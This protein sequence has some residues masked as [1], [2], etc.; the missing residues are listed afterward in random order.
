MSATDP[1]KP[2]IH[3]GSTEEPSPYVIDLRRAEERQEQE[4]QPVSRPIH[5]IE[6]LLITREDVGSQLLENDFTSPL[7]QIEEPNRH[8]SIAEELHCLHEEAME[9]AYGGL[10]LPEF[11]MT[12][13]SLEQA[14]FIELFEEEEKTEEPE[15][16]K[17]FSFRIPVPEH[18]GR[19]LVSFVG[20]SFILV[21]PIHAM[22]SVDRLKSDQ[23]AVI[24]SGASALSNL[25]RGMHAVQT[26]SFELAKQ[27]FAS[28]Q[29]HFASAENKLKSFDGSLQFFLSVLPTT[30]SAYR[31][32]NALVT[33]GEKLSYAAGLFALALDDIENVTS[34]EPIVKLDILI[35]YLEQMLPLLTDANN[36]L[37]NVD[38]AQVPAAYQDQFSQISTELPAFVASL[39][40]FLRFSQTI[41]TL[42]GANDPMRYLVLFQNDTEIRPTGGFIGSFAEITINHGAI[43]NIS[44]PGGGS[45]DLQGTLSAFVEAPAP[46]QLINARFEFQDGNWFPDFPTSA[47]KLLWFYDASNGPTVDGVIAL[48]ASYM[49][50]M[51]ALLGS[52]DMPEYDR[53][54]T[55][56]N[57]LLETQKIVE[58]EC[59]RE[60]NKP[61]Q[62]IADLAPK[63]LDKIEEASTET[64]L[65]VLEKV[66][67]GFTEKEIQVYVKN[68]KLMHMITELG[69]D[70]AIKQTAGDYL[71]I[72]DANIGGGKTDGT[73]R[74]SVALD[75][76]IQNDGSFEN[77]LTI[78]REHPGAKGDLFSGVNNVDYLRVYV[79]EGATLLSATGDFTP[80]DDS[81]FEKSDLDLEFDPDLQQIQTAVSK[82]TTSGTDI[83][84]EFGKTVFGNWI[85]T[86]P[87]ATSTVQF[88][89]RLPFSLQ[90]EKPEGLWNKLTEWA[91]GKKHLTYTM[92][93][94][95]QSGANNRT[96]SLRL[97]QNEKFIPLWA[98]DQALL[99]DTLTVNNQ[100]DLFVAT[101]FDQID[102]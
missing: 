20:L 8:E 77:T 99:E 35:T 50:E 66:G 49:A 72:I 40:D 30:R 81:L 68:P 42:L 2:K 95:K 59:D 76:H 13:I 98:S 62:F 16:K 33:S 93:L 75:I 26:E 25:S 4:A 21:L 6:R 79:P 83:S 19:I 88:K 39:S 96:V 61:K 70:G 38:I 27:D 15:A 5:P 10:E 43:E 32:A 1:K 100:A 97:F 84:Q 91:Q 60:E 86:K 78:T 28:A 64:F 56:D 87:G 65:D 34:N 67:E 82:D 24:T 85:Q 11:E 63:L 94:Q 58:L 31:S 74:E 51:L 14:E 52:I 12:E 69:Y 44:I 92:L 71:M 22:Q 89:Y 37:L 55:S 101:L 29:S 54:I 48:N 18:F 23:Q 47:K 102:L 73:I 53:T 41:E 9:N 17:R 7:L 3:L 45:Y 90:E 80:P 46:L 57:F 36:N